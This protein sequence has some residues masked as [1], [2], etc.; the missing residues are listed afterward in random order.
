M[1][2]VG[3]FTLSLLFVLFLSPSVFAAKSKASAD[4]EIVSMDG[5]TMVLK[6]KKS[7]E[8]FKLNSDTE[9]RRANEELSAGHF[10]VGDRVRVKYRVE[11]EDKI[12]V[13]VEMWIPPHKVRRGGV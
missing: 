4:G 13:R 7:E 12:A 1:R 6:V 5:R 3:F 8:S 10:K 9:Y 2:R 11:E